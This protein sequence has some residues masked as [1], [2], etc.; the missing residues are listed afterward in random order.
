MFVRKLWRQLSDDSSVLRNS[1]QIIEGDDG[2]AELVFIEPPQT[3]TKTDPPR[4]DASPVKTLPDEEVDETSFKSR[5]ISFFTERTMKK[6]TKQRLVLF[7]VVFVLI[8]IIVGIVLGTKDKRESSSQ[9]EKPAEATDAPTSVNFF[10]N[11][12][13]DKATILLPDG[14]A[15]VGII[16]EASLSTFNVESDLCGD[17]TFD[18]G[19]GKW[20]VVSGTGQTLNLTACEIGCS[21]PDTALI[22]PE[23]SIFV[24]NC[25]AMYCVDGTSDLIQENPFQFEAFRGQDYFI[26]V[27]G[28]NDTVGLFE[29]S[30][31]EA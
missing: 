29:I 8:L 14:V 7:G 25:D 22:V 30:V 15:D 16:S 26:Y 13:C 1:P 23:V 10:T 27:Q 18:G 24:G 9:A 21:A 4:P 20:Y 11:D 3:P 19:P 31:V 2:A 12:K 5:N 28:A 17:A 6:E